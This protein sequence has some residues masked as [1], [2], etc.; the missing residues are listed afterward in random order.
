MRHAGAL[1]EQ[2]A[3]HF[4]IQPGAM[5]G[6]IAHEAATQEHNPPPSFIGRHGRIVVKFDPIR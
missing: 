5:E 6:Q 1:V 2:F 4:S 3:L